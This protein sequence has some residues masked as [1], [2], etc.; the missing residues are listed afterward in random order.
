M[1]YM[2]FPG[3]GSFRIVKNCDRGLENAARGRTKTLDKGRCFKEQIYLSYFMMVAS[4]SL[5]K[6]S[7][8]VFQV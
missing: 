7:K 5:V 2:L 3:L 4:S 8:I 1:L 6:F